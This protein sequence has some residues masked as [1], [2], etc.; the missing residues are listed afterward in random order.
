MKK[1]IIFIL[2]VGLL[3]CSYGKQHVE[4]MLDNPPGVLADPL[5]EDYEAHLDALER[6]YLR[7]EIS[8]A[9]YVE[10][11]QELEDQYA[12]ESNKR[13]AIIEGE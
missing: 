1:M 13:I 10:Q 5:Y 3:G 6:Q 4:Y 9:D 11:K 12:R 8:Y 2:A 7:K